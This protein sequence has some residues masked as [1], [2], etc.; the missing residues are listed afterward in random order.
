ML[1]AGMALGRPRPAYIEIPLDVAAAALDAAPQPAAAPPH[2]F[3]PGPDH[4]AIA[5]AAAAIG[6]A[7]RP[8]V[9]LGGGAVAAAAAARALVA[10]I[11]AVA[12]TTIAGKGILPETDPATLGASLNEPATRALIDEADLVIAIGTELASPDH[13]LD[14]LPIRPPLIRIDLDPAV[15]AR[16]HPAMLGILADAGLALA[17][18]DAALPE[19]PRPCWHQGCAA[20]RQAQHERLRR[21]RPEHALVLDALARALPEDAILATDMTQIAYSGNGY[22][23]SARPAT[24]LHPAGFGTLGY[25]LPAAIGASLAQPGRRVVALAGDYG[26]GFT[27]AEL[28]TARDLALPL[29]V[30]VWNNGGLGQIAQ[31][32]DR[33][34]IPRLGV[35]I[36]PPDFARLAQG[37]GAAYR[38]PPTLAELAGALAEAAA[39]AGPTLI[40]I[41]PE[42]AR[43]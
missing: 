43:A 37:Y 10:R 19:G 17:A 42:A 40:E 11:G 38:R 9:I 13:F 31:D 26:I 32:M 34:Q 20:M 39:Q 16:D 14:L 29:P 12:V 25:A 23:P 15:L 7:R 30:V 21:E 41:T 27:L 8:V 3:R 2:L 33:R 35:E 6:R 18:L 28:A 4:A 1:M 24:W 36:A 22:Y 5:R